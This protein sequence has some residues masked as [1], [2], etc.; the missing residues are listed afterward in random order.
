MTVAQGGGLG[1]ETNP[2]TIL[3]CQCRAESS[4]TGAEPQWG[5]STIF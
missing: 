1:H 5:T 2:Q 3:K 4:N